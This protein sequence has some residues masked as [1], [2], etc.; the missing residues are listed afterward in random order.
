MNKPPFS[1]PLPSVA[2][3]IVWP[4]V[5]TPMAAQRISQLYYFATSER[6]SPDKLHDLQFTQILEVMNFARQTVPYYQEKFAYL[7]PFTNAQELQAA[8]QD[9]PLLTRMDLQKAKEQI[10]TLNPIP[11]HEPSELM[12]STGSTGLPVSVKA[13]VATQFFWNILTLRDHIWH[14]N[15][16]AGTAAVIRFTEN[17]AAQPP[18]GAVF[19]NWGPATY[20]VVPTGKC[21]QLTICTTEEEVTWLR[22]VNPHYLH[23]NSSTLREITQ[24]F[25]THGGIPSNL[26]SVHTNSEIVEADLRQLVKQVLGVPLVDTY[27][28]KE[29]GYI[30]LQCP[31]HEHYHVQSEN[32]LVEILN[33]NGEPC[34]VD[35][36]G[37]V[38]VT[39]LHNFASPLIRYVVGDYAIPGE[40]CACGR[41]LPVLKK[42]LGRQRNVIK[43]PDGRR[44]WPSFA[45][46]GVRLMDMFAGA[47]FQVIQ[48]A[49]TEI[50]INLA[51][52]SP[53][54]PEQEEKLKAQLAIVFGH[55]FTFIFNYL[56]KIER[57]PGGKYEDFKCEC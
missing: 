22:E 17:P 40:P 14:Q 8:W 13:N 27:S 53:F 20:Q 38:V 28:A 16:F 15:D 6:Y 35:E 7:P 42:V 33:D 4:I 39:A 36:P 37:R 57:G 12:T 25:A 49:L 45:S 1:L 10:F 23:C 46:N 55:P 19:E 31:E 47:Q 34:A 41:T 11:S 24:Y 48:K 30:A 29:L 56:E 32:L 2:A 52:I 18:H 50:H 51:H 9:I 21:H 54:T 3:G 44:I 5:P 43:M 26:R